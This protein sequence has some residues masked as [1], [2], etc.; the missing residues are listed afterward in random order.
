MTARAILTCA[1][2]GCTFRHSVEDKTFDEA[3]RRARLRFEKRCGLYYCPPCAA[4]KAREVTH[5][6]R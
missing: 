4:R 3:Q 5:D 1:Q 2:P 6:A